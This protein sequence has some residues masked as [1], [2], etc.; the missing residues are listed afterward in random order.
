MFTLTSSSSQAF[1]SYTE[2]F[3]AE[4]EA[5]LP[6]LGVPS[7]QVSRANACFVSQSV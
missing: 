1:E 4:L 3:Y 7:E 6:Q 2:E 5:N